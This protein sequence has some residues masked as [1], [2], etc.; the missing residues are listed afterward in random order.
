MATDSNSTS[1]WQH[2][3]DDA[4]RVRRTRTRDDMDVEFSPP[5]PEAQHEAAAAA[6]GPAAQMPLPANTA[7]PQRGAGPRGQTAAAFAERAG[8]V[9]DFKSICKPMSFDGAESRWLEWKFRTKNSFV[10][11]GL[12]DAERYAADHSEE[13][14]PNTVLPQNLIGASEFLYSFLVQTCSGKALLIVRLCNEGNGILAWKKLLNAYEPRQAMRFTAM[15]SHLLTPRWIEGI[16]FSSQWLQ[17]EQEMDMYEQACVGKVPDAVKCAVILRWAPKPIREY[18]RSCPIDATTNYPMMKHQLETYFLRNRTYDD[19]GQTQTDALGINEVLAWIQWKGK[20]K[21]KGKGKFGKG[22]DKGKKGKGKDKFGKGKGK[23]KP[24]GKGAAG[25]SGTGSASSSQQP[26]SGQF[27]GYCSR[28]FLWGHKRADCR[29]AMPIEEEEDYEG[30]ADDWWS[31]ADY[32]WDDWWNDADYGWEDYWQDEADESG[33][34]AA[35]AALETTSTIQ[36]FSDQEKRQVQQTDLGGAAMTVGDIGPSEAIFLSVMQDGTYETEAETELLEP[37]PGCGYRKCVSAECPHVG[38]SSHL[39][40]LQRQRLEVGRNLFQSRQPQRLLDKAEVFCL[41]F[42]QGVCLDEAQSLAERW[43]NMIRDDVLNEFQHFQQQQ[44]DEMSEFLDEAEDD[45]VDDSQDFQGQNDTVPEDLNN[46]EDAADLNTNVETS[47]SMPSLIGDS[48]SDDETVL[49]SPVE[50]VPGEAELSRLEEALGVTLIMIDSGAFDHVCPQG[51][52]SGLVSSHLRKIVTATGSEVAHYGQRQVKF[53]VWD[54]H[55]AVATF[56]VCDVNRPIVSVGT[57]TD[58]GLAVHFDKKKSVLTLENNLHFPL[59]KQKGLYY[60]PVALEEFEAHAVELDNSINMDGDD[61]GM[62]T[63]LDDDK[64]DLLPLGGDE[65]SEE[66]DE[67]RQQQES[68][69]P[70][71]SLQTKE[72]TNQQREDHS[73]THVPFQ[74]WCEECIVGRGRDKGH[75]YTL[76]QD[77]EELEELI[78]LVQL[79]YFFVKIHNHE[80]VAPVL[81]GAFAQNH[82]G[83]AAM[84]RGKGREDARA[85]PMLCTWLQECGLFGQIKVRVDQEPFILAIAQDLA[86]KRGLEKT[87]IETVPKLSKGSIGSADRFGQS[88]VGLARSLCADFE[89]YWKIELTVDSPIV[90]WAIRHAA[91]LLNRFQPHRR[92]K[93]KTSYQNIYRQPY[94][95]EL[96]QFGR[97]VVGRLPDALELPKLQPRWRRGIWLGKT[98]ESDAHLLGCENGLM[99]TRTCRQ[100]L[101]GGERDKDTLMKMRWTPWS[102]GDFKQS[103]DDKVKVQRIPKMPDSLPPMSEQ[104][105]KRKTPG[106]GFYTEKAKR[107][108]NFQQECGMTPACQACREGG[109]SQ[110]HSSECKR[111]QREWEQEK[112]Q[113]EESDTEMDTDEDPKLKESTSPSSRRI[114]RRVTGKQSPEDIEME[115]RGQ[116]RGLESPEEASDISWI[117]TKPPWRD[118]ETMEPLDEDAVEKG[119][120]YEREK[121]TK[122]DVFDWATWDEYQ[123]CVDDGCEPLLIQSG[124]VMRKKPDSVRCRCVAQQVSDGSDPDSYYCPTP[125]QVAHRIVVAQAAHENWTIYPG[126]VAAAFLNTPVDDNEKIFIIPPKSETMNRQDDKQLWRLKVYMYGLRVA[127]K[128]WGQYFADQI[129]NFGWKRTTGEPQLFVNSK[130]KGALMSVHTDDLFLTASPDVVEELKSELGLKMKIKWQQPIGNDWQRYVGYEWRNLD[131]KFQCRSPLDYYD[132]LFEDWRLLKAKAAVNPFSTL[133]RQKIEEEEQVDQVTHRRYRRAAGKLLWTIPV[134]VD[135]G[136]AAKEIA[137]SASAPKPSHLTA[138]KRCLKYLKGSRNSVLTLTGHRDDGG[139]QVFSDADWKSPKSTSGAVF[140]WRGTLL[141]VWGRTQ[142]VPTQS[143]AEAEV[144]AMNEAAKE[145]KFLHGLLGEVVGETVDVTLFSDASSAVSFSKRQGFGR[146]RHLELKE[147]WIQEQL[148]QGWLHVEKVET[149]CNPADL[150]TKAYKSQTDF[151]MH[152]AQLQ[153]SN[154]GDEQATVTSLVPDGDACGQCGSY[155][156]LWCRFCGMKICESCACGC[157]E[158]EKVW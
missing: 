147:L 83:F 7:L 105:G 47:D 148:G 51:F 25:S 44:E 100:L 61:D 153:L 39:Q 107:I 109:I 38:C 150:F 75:H 28:C 134:R 32:G 42:W 21:G 29:V 144:I 50:P 151:E 89:K 137:R 88:A 120:E 135:I 91:F 130:H 43:Q 143:S 117:Q 92:A 81:V 156:L 140:L 145:A 35:T 70:E 99:V 111:R 24:S 97:L 59:V 71:P 23:L 53:R 114:K 96:Q 54:Q 41:L 2:V 55:P 116:K 108:R 26:A 68:S 80:K 136:F 9:M 95:G 37:C 31:Y 86:V 128:K 79:D 133:S 3:E 34:S 56:H 113:H 63:D 10:V 124:W 74:S 126:D 104:D 149:S 49:L 102:L 138:L 60:L 84:M 69:S 13:N 77:P 5:M 64:D 15:L 20:D 33:C 112:G 115:K 141:E 4:D 67:Q 22:K 98:V 45:V 110:H 6:A 11:L 90:P 152:K 93:G 85:V 58:K 139:L 122:M 87:L 52:G 73:R 19:L 119:F 123:Q 132:N 146:M 57:L 40:V 155:G 142:S 65:G 121:W 118:P 78:P 46:E 157:D 72:P 14:L 158:R 131:G 103:D 62:D 127:P 17:W 48:D 125:R 82:Y 8:K 94:H 18:L 16:D 76:K 106:G 1:S 101:L 27:Q 12:Q 66:E 30:D 36:G 154:E 129:Q